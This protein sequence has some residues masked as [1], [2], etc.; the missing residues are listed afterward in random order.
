MD[1]ELAKQLRDAGFPQGGNGRWAGNPDKIVWRSGDRAYV[2][3]L[4]EL[5][6]AW[7]DKFF[8]LNATDTRGLSHTWYAA[9]TFPNLIEATGSTP[10]EAVAK[11]WLALNKVQ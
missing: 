3:T 10:T 11:V 4:E 8:A 9:V 5:I 7:G 6:D 2:P 1:Y